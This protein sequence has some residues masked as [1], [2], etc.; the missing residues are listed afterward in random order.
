MNTIVISYRRQDSRDPA[1]MLLERLLHY[2][3]GRVVLGL[4]GLLPGENVR[5]KAEQQMQECRLLL[6]LIGPDWPHLADDR[7]RPRLQDRRDWVRL[8]IAAAL[9]RRVP[10]V[11]V[12]LGSTPMPHEDELPAELHGLLDVQPQRLADGAG[13]AAAL[14]ALVATIRQQLGEGDELLALAGAASSAAALAAT[15]TPVAAPAAVAA[16]AGLAAGALAS[17]PAAPTAAAGAAVLPLRRGDGRRVAPEPA[18]VS[19]W[20]GLAA[21]DER[22]AWAAAWGEDGFGRWADIEVAG[23]RQRLRR[24]EPGMFLMGAEP[25]AGD[26]FDDELP[27]HPV[28]LTHGFWLADTV[29]S[30]ALWA[31]LLGDDPGRWRARPDLP[32]DSVSWNDIQALFL[33]SLAHELGAGTRARLPTEAEWEYACR[34]GSRATFHFGDSASPRWMRFGGDTEGPVPVQA[35]PPNAW[36]LHQMH[37]NVWEWCQ[38]AKRRYLAE[39]ALDP[40]GGSADVNRVLRGGSWAGP[41]RWAR[42]SCRFEAPRSQRLDDA[43]FRFVLE[44]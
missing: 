31:A 15:V 22:P 41:A 32:V 11:P 29:C 24:I 17:V 6:V 39:P 35:L 9:Q 28:T 10:V 12:L 26:R 34:A 37:G 7:G 42:S 19:S 21:A 36:G 13:R 14:A 40:R 20:P 5:L 3:P 33:P 25:A 38:D 43:G 30:R 4:E 16:N 27:R 18:S 2:F 8:E 44:D 1:R 23:V